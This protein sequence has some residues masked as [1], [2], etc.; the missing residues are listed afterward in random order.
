MH[1]FQDKTKS[2]FSINYRLYTKSLLIENISRAHNFTFILFTF[3]TKS[4]FD[5]YA[6]NKFF[7]ETHMKDIL[8]NILRSSGE[9]VLSMAEQFSVR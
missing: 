6:R 2:C 7:V 3:S 1:E 8:K 9:E 4:V 5:A